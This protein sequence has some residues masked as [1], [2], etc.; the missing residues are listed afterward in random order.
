MLLWFQKTLTFV[1]DGDSIQQ[2]ESCLS[3]SLK[4]I[5]ALFRHALIQKSVYV[6]PLVQ[7]DDATGQNSIQECSKM[8]SQ[9][10]P[11]GP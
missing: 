6:F 2:S 3:W 11:I 9:S 1:W 7:R 5:L 8:T 10:A 4:G